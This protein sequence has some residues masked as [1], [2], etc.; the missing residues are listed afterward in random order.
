MDWPTSDARKMAP[1]NSVRLCSRTHRIGSVVRRADDDVEDD[2]RENERQVR[3]EH[4]PHPV[5]VARG[6]DGTTGELRHGR[7]VVRLRHPD[8]LW[9]RDEGITKADVVAYYREV[10]P[11]LLPHL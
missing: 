5:M 2:A 7:R 4:R 8:Q 10:S 11:V 3:R 9:W 6:A 1:K